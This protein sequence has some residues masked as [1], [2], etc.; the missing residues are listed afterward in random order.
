MDS[1]QRSAVSTFQRSVETNTITVGAAPPSNGD[2]MTWA[3]SVQENPVP[4][5]YSLSPV[6]DLFTATYAEDLP[7]IDLKTMR[8]KLI[9]TSRNYC[10]ILREKGEID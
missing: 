3:S 4:T 5:K 7:E 6:H 8:E 10:R 9:N 1:E 2:A